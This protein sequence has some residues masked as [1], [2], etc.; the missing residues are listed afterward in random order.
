MNRITWLIYLFSFSLRLVAGNSPISCGI[1]LV[2][3]PLLVYYFWWLYEWHVLT[4]T[5][6]VFIFKHWFLSLVLFSSAIIG[7]FSST[8]Y[9]G[10]YELLYHALQSLE[11]EHSLSAELRKVPQVE[12]LCLWNLF[13]WCPP[14][15]WSSIVHDCSKTLTGGA[16]C[17][18]LMSTRLAVSL[19]WMKATMLR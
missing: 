3:L 9:V 16:W 12:G 1:Y 10:I 4:G 14:C 17:I 5:T 2:I 7:P 6:F 19:G 13:L 18:R 8:E 15:L 11:V